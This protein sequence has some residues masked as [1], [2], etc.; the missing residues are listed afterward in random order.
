M[1]NTI[2][3]IYS[4]RGDAEAFLA[5]PYIYN[6]AGEWIGFITSQRDV[7]SVLGYYVGTLTNDPRIICNRSS[8]AKPRLKPPLRPAPMRISASIP[9][10]KMMGDLNPGCVDILQD[11][12]HRLHT[13]DAGE[14]RQDMD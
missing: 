14:F 10:P 2:I 9:L 4:S 12:P 11:E 13:L 1:T 5:F 6:R 8:E 3:P 7:Y